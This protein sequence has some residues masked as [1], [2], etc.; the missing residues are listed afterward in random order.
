MKYGYGRI[1]TVGKHQKLD[2]QLKVLMDNVEGLSLEN[3]YTDK[4]T[5]TV[6]DRPGLNELKS[7]L[8]SG[9]ELW[10]E[11]LSRLSR[12][13]QDLLEQV[14]EFNENGIIFHSI[15]ENFDFS[16]ATGRLLLS[17]IAAIVAFERDLIAERVKEGVEVAR[18][19]GKRIGRPPVSQE[20]LENAVKLY[21]SGN[22]SVKAVLD[23]V[24]ISKS[25]LYKELKKIR[26]KEMLENE[27]SGTI[28]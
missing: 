25:S 5:G 9:D 26:D 22:Y 4:I 20:K 10:V 18:L 12:S 21:Y 14:S 13:T 17:M 7:K 3:I 2:R 11:S 8:Q 19:K 1:S 16:S 27:K 23:M 6:K 28:L 24:G 15:K